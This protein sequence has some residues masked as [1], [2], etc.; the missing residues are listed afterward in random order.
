V[1]FRVFKNAVCY[2]P[3]FDPVAITPV[4]TR[5]SFE[6]GC[7]GSF[8]EQRHIWPKFCKF[9]DSLVFELNNKTTNTLRANDSAAIHDRLNLR[10]RRLRGRC[11]QK[12]A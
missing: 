2:I 6:S 8:N 4:R 3:K 10:G 9:R 12:Q 5:R 7:S 1:I 11:L